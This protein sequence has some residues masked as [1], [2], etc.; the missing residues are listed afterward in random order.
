MSRSYPK[1]QTIETNMAAFREAVSEMDADTQ[2][3][4]RTAI[5]DVAGYMYSIGYPRKMETAR[6]NA[7]LVVAQMINAG[8]YDR[9]MIGV[10]TA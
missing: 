2:R 8:D 5:E 3:F 1:N 7:E 9:L 6:Q 10:L 4:V